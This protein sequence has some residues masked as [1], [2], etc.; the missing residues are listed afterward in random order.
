MIISPIV[1]HDGFGAALFHKRA[2]GEQAAGGEKGLVSSVAYEGGVEHASEIGR[3]D[4]SS[5]KGEGQS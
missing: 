5:L 4:E 3:R 2:S 1:Y